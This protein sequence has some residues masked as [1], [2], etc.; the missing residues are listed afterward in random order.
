[1]GNQTKRIREIVRKIIETRSSAQM[2]SFGQMQVWRPSR[3]QFEKGISATISVVIRAPIG[4]GAQRKITQARALTR[5]QM[6]TPCHHLAPGKRLRSSFPSSCLDRKSYVGRLPENGF[7]SNKGSFSFDLRNLKGPLLLPL[8][9]VE[10]QLLL[11][12]RTKG[13]EILEEREL[14]PRSCWKDRSEEIV[15]SATVSGAACD[16]C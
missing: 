2:V 16:S 1:M 3:H 15:P 8:L 4:Y 14:C 5:E 13:L 10:P 9:E 7:S 12:R 11:L 6:K